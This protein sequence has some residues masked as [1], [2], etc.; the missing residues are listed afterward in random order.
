MTWINYRN[1]PFANG[2]VRKDKLEGR[3]RARA[4][5][6]EIVSWKE[7]DKEDLTSN[8]SREEEEEEEEEEEFT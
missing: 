5:E 3:E 6:R 4:S 8:L 1:R 7:R 2:C